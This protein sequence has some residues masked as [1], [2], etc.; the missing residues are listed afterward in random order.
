QGDAAH[1]ECRDRQGAEPDR[2]PRR[3]LR[4]G[5]SRWQAPR[6]KRLERPDRARLGCGDRQGTA[7]IRRPYRPRRQ[8]GVL[9]RRQAHR[10]RQP[11]RHGA[12]L[13]RAALTSSRKEPNLTTWLIRWFA[14]L[15]LALPFVPSIAAPDDKA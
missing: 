4:R 6:L 7:Q 10:L 13:A 14:L 12:H 11:R 9:P 5:F 3:D 8:L 1:L 15:V 2:R